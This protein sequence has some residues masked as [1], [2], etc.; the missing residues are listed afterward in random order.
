MM[1]PLYYTGVPVGHGMTT[2]SMYTGIV[3]HELMQANFFDD[4]QL[5]L[6]DTSN[7]LALFSLPSHHF[8]LIP[9]YTCR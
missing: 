7:P 3:I 6:Y 9:S 1:I 4:L 5:F 8:I 2:I